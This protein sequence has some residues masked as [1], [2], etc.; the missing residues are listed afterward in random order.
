[1]K[2]S[3][4][5]TGFT[6]LELSIVII[7]IGL[8]IGGILMG[9]DLIHAAEIRKTISQIQQIKTNIRAFKLKYGKYPGDF[10]K[11]SQFWPSA[12][13]IDGNGDGKIETNESNSSYY[14][15]ENMFHHLN[16]AELMPGDYS[17]VSSLP[18]PAGQHCMAPLELKQSQIGINYLKPWPVSAK[19][20]TANWLIVVGTKEQT[21]AT[22][23]NLLGS[24]LG[25][26]ADLETTPVGILGK[27][28]WAIDS[29]T[30]DGKPFTGTAMGNL[31][32]MSE[33]EKL[34]CTMTD[35]SNAY[36]I[37]NI[38]LNCQLLTLMDAN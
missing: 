19:A 15:S 30:D 13:A 20:L 14:E 11:A 25:N 18:L 33:D 37:T 38:Y 16:L 10:N 29:K 24:L 5:R 21:L 1:M 3:S 28:A 35:D 2:P 8:I 27:D 7:V 4:Y 17:A 22:F 32:N 26:Y 34:S 12:G 36:N 23:G 6:L 9:G 31:P